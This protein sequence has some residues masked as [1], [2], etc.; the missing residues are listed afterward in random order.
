ME[1]GRDHLSPSLLSS[2]GETLSLARSG[3]SEDRLWFAEHWRTDL[4]SNA[5]SMYW[6]NTVWGLFRKL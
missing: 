4:F 1:V 2:G 5:V 3:E 6:E